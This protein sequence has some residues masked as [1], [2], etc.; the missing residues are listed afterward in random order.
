MLVDI[1][2]LLFKWLFVRKYLIT[3]ST[4]L[5]TQVRINRMNQRKRISCRLNPE[6]MDE[7]KDS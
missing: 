2:Y 4:S 7:M 3:M 1:G 6:N 5:Y